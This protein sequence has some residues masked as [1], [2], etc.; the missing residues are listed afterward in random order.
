[1]WKKNEWHTFIKKKTSSNMVY[2]G[3]K[4][5]CYNQKDVTDSKD[6][7]KFTKIILY[8]LHTMLNPWW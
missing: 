6:V 3:K 2:T 1:M 5:S 8:M 4:A 7:N